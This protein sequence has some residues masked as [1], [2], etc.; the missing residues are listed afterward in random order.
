MPSLLA[1]VA[2]E[3]AI[4]HF[5]RAFSYLIPEGMNVRAGCRVA[6]PFGRGNSKRQGVV[7]SVGEGEGENLKYIAELLDDEPVLNDEMLK[8]CAFMKSHCFCTY[9]DALKAMLPAGINYRL[10][11]E[12]SVCH[13]LGDCFYDLPDEWRRIVSIIRSKNNKVEKY[14]LLQELG[15]ADAAV[16]D[17]MTAD[18]VLYKNDAAFRKIGDK[19]VKMMRLCEDID[20]RLSGVKLSSKQQSVIDLLQTVGA[21]SVKEICYYTGVTPSVPDA[22]VKKGLADYFDDE[23]FRIPRSSVFEKR[24]ITLTEEQQTAFDELCALYERDT[25][26]VSLLYGVTG[27]GKTSVFFKLIERAVSDGKDVIVMVPE[28]A[29]TPQM[30][31]IFKASFGDRVAVFHS[32]L[33]LGERLDEYKRVSR[34][35]AKIAIGTRSAI[36]APFKNL[37]LIIIDEEQE[38]TYKSEARP[39]FNAKELSRFRSSYHRSLLVLSSATPSVETFYYAEE[40][41]YHK[42][43]LTKRYGSATLPD[44]VIAD[45]NEE[46]GIG[47]TSAFSNILLENI[48]ENLN[49]GKQSILLLNRRGFNSF[50]TCNSCKEP[51]TCPNCSISLTYHSANNRLM[52]HYCGYSVRY[53]GECPTCRSHSLRLSGTGTQKAEVE[54]TEIFP[55]A[56]I[57]RMDTDATMTRSSHEKKLTAFANGEYDILV[58]T[59]MVAKGLD[60]PNVTLVG[61]L[62]ADRMLYL[63]DFRSYEN[64]FSLLTQVVGRSGRGRDKG[65]AIIQTFT[66]ENPIIS[67]AARQDYDAFYASEIGIRRAMLY[68]PFAAI[69]MVGF[70]GENAK[71]TENAAFAFTNKMTALIRAEYPDIPLRLLGPSQA[72]VFKVSNKYRFKLIL[73]CRNDARFREMLGRMLVDF[74]AERDYSSVTVYADMDPLSI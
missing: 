2:V 55:Q 15:Y 32:A 6:V 4:Y 14:A 5:D 35:L 43:T 52:C 17:E 10:S 24:D 13:T 38:H 1:Y 44:V 34:G 73:K 45:M 70:V 71:L 29:L 26:E 18:G 48:E 60:F 25:P 74:S 47:N 20:D 12:Y 62:N 72:G 39:R 28:I 16:L 54:L 19:T 56:R 8:M 33:S 63:D 49:K 11:Q 51:L 53:T 42:H 23:V 59:Q 67:L 64:T 30:I 57:L 36:F 41:R 22:L 58:G 9:Y 37:G 50:V 40:G 66:P 7:L 46:L 21:A 31:A 65:R 68:P 69:C 61:V 27:S 3:N